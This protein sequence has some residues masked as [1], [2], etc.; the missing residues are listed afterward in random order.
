[1]GILH[2]SQVEGRDIRDPD[3]WFFRVARDEH[4]AIIEDTAGRNLTQYPVE[5]PQAMLG[6][7]AYRMITDPATAGISVETWSQVFFQAMN[8]FNFGS[9]FQS[10]S[11]Y[12]LDAAKEHGFTSI[13]RAA[14]ER[15]FES[16][17]A[18]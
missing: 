11:G 16:I 18:L 9:M 2:Q 6:H 8:N 5:D 3:L 1:M 14:I 15:A 17:S 7:I 13:Q 12:V 10:V 4:G